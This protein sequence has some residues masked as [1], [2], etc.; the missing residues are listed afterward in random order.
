MDSSTM[1]QTS[2]VLFLLTALGGLVMG[3]IRFMGGRNPPSSLAMAHGLLAG[4]G[5]TLLV[6]AAVAGEVP[7]AAVYAAVLFVLAAAGGVAM[8]LAWHL[9]DRPLPKGLTVVHALLA[10]AAFALL[11]VAAFG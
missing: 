4:A 9:R 2:A 7:Q 1:L 5:L 8:N 6:Y 11:L 3:A 10:V